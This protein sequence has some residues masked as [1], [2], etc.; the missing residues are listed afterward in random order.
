LKEELDATRL[1]Y[2]PGNGL[3]AKEFTMRNDVQIL[4]EDDEGIL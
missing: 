4:D 3:A 2:D 1:K